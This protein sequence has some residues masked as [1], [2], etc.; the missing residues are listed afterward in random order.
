MRATSGQRVQFRSVLSV[1]TTQRSSTTDTRLILSPRRWLVLHIV[2]MQ[3]RYTEDM[4]LAMPR[5]RLVDY[6]LRIN[7]SF[8]C[9]RLY[10][11]VVRTEPVSSLLVR[12]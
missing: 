4:V 2:M 5:T 1:C 6:V 9:P 11:E 7:F 8:G 12:R 3:T 10:T